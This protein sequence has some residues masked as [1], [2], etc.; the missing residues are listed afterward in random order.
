MGRTACKLAVP[1]L[2]VALAGRSAAEPETDPLADYR[3][4]EALVAMDQGDFQRALDLSL[5]VVMQDPKD[6]RAHREAGRAA[7]AL[8]QLQVAVDELERAL[9]LGAGEPDPEAHYLAGEAYYVLGR[10]RDA[11]RHHDQALRE[12]APDTTSWMELLWLAR[13]HARRHQLDAADAIYRGLLAREPDSVEVQIARIEAFTLS[14]RWADAERLLLDF[15][16]NHAD[17]ARAAEMLAWVLEAQDRL[18]EERAVRAGL[19]D[20]PTRVGPQP[21]LDHA[22]ALERSGLYR[23]AIARYREALADDDLDSHPAAELDARAALSRLTHRMSPEVSVAAG[24]FS[25]PS[26]SLYRVRSGA[27]VPAADQLS[28]SLVASLD[29]AAA[30]SAPGASPAGGVRIGTLDASATAGEGRL[31]ASSLTLSGSWFSFDDA[32][33]H[34]RIGTAFD[35]RVG[36]GK[37]IQLRASGDLNMPWRETASTMREGGRETGATAMAYGLPFG[38]RVILGAGARLRWL[39]LDPIMEVDATGSQAM[40]IAGADW[41]AWAPSYRVTRGQFLDEDLRWGTSV[42]A[43]SLTLSYRHYEAFT[44]DDFAG[45]LVLAERGTID[46]VST[47]ARNTWPDGWFGFEVRGGAGLDRARDTRLW[48]AG[49]SLLL[50]PLERVRGA[51]SYDYAEESATGFAGVRHT[52]L[53]SIHVDL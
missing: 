39:A 48:R 13:I 32:E 30:G 3:L 15:I 17:H 19:A 53:G 33:S 47:V 6:A 18:D 45:R 10:T 41:V 24:T 26:G 5:R 8:G 42:L 52:A 27:A 22:R 36:E 40:L 44:E 7:H 25:D 46:E 49:G 9:A 16:A 12:I 2:L 35:L 28:L 50:T 20:D 1:A 21:L 37:R 29:W 4:E 38:D 34:G 23:A 43:D 11:V 51:L 14:K 31:V